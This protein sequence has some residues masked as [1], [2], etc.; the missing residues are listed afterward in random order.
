MEQH[1]PVIKAL[2]VMEV[3]RD[4]T[5]VKGNSPYHLAAITTKPIIE[6]WRSYSVTR[7]EE[8]RGLFG[9]E[10]K[11]KKYV[12]FYSIFKMM[13]DRS[14]TLFADIWRPFCS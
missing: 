11:A 8:E 1:V 5:D 6:V 10:L 9:L 12:S 13:S 14:L 2:L 3:S 7:L 4:V